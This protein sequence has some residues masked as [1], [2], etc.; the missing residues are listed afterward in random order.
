VKALYS[1][2]HKS[3]KKEIKDMRRW[4]DLASSW[5]SKRNIKITILQKAFCKLYAISIKI[6]MSQK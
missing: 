6:P 4:K 5:I 1:G 3:L 2:N